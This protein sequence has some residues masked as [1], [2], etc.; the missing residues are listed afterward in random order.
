MGSQL[1]AERAGSQ[2]PDLDVFPRA[3]N[4]L[5]HLAGFRGQEVAHEL[6]DIL[7]ELIHIRRQIAPHCSGRD[8]IGPRRPAEAEID[9]P[10]VKGREGAELLGDQQRRVVRQHDAAR[11]DTDRAGRDRDMRQG[12]RG[13][14]AGDPRHVV[15]LRHPVAMIT[16]RLHVTGEV[17]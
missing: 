12:Y 10:G 7:G 6:H 5:Q 9:P 13:G 3:G 8:L 15:V 16:Q 4:R 17:D 14:G 1:R 11:P 2:D